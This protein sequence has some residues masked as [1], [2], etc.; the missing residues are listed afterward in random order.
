MLEPVPS[1]QVVRFGTY[2]LDLRLGEL[3]KSGIRVKLS[4]QPFQILVILLERP[5][6]LVTREQLQQRLWPSDTFVD[7]DRG[8]NAAINRVREALGDSAEN[9]RFVETL[10]R[11]GYRFIAPLVDSR[12]ARAMLPAAESN[13]SPEQAV[14]SSGALPVSEAS[15]RKPFSRRLKLLLGGASILAVLAV[16]VAL[17]SK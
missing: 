10:P 2:E 3:R 8:L 15:E 12:P 11:R 6:D 9:P 1:V 7:F 17:L 13:V 5:G 16:A 14:T 4:G